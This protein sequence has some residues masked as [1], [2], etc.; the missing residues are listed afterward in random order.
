MKRLASDNFFKRISALAAAFV[1]LWLCSCNGAVS[2]NTE[3]SVE[4]FAMDTFVQIKAYGENADDALQMA[5]NEVRRLESLFSVNNENSEIFLLNHERSIVASG[6]TLEIVL[7]SLIISS[8]TSGAFD[9]SVYPLVLLYGFTTG[10]YSVPAQ[11][12]IDSALANVGYENISINDDVI[13][14][15]NGALIDLGAVAKGYCADRVAQI[16]LDCGVSGAVISLGGNVA[17]CGKKPNNDDFLVAITDPLNPQQI[18]GHVNVSDCSVVTS[19]AYQRYFEENGKKYHHIINPKTG[20][21]ADSGLLSVTVISENGL[22]ADALSTAFFVQGK[23]AVYDYVAQNDDVCVI[24]VD[25]D[26]NVGVVGNADFTPNS[27]SDYNY[28]T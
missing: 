7:Q 1:M 28:L 22:K 23:T 5:Q 27:A 9:I 17:V 18:I 26:K 11:S 14:L 8:Q 20:L 13:T 10:N 3:K 6:E 15:E 12:D 21:C 19:G 4:F 25:I 2:E 24:Y 16:M